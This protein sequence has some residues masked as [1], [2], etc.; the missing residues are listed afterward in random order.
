MAGSNRLSLGSL[1][2]LDA[3]RPL[4]D[5]VYQVLRD[6]IIDGR[7]EAGQWLRQEAL[8]QELGVSQMPIREALKRLV[9]E[10]LAER[11]PYRG[12]QVVEFAPR[13]IADMCTVRL[14]LESLAVRFAATQVTAEQIA[15]LKE[16]LREA[17]TCTR[18]EEMARRRQ[19]N[20]EFHLNICHASEHRY[21]IRQLDA[22]WDWFPSVMLYEG[23]RRQEELS[24]M[25]LERESQEHWAILSAIEEGDP[26]QA[27]ENTRQHI[28][29]LSLELAE[30]LGIREELIEPLMDLSRPPHCRGTGT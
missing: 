12:V 18:H 29:N 10:G 7:F 2:I 11:I 30:V 23:M 27:E 14:I 13:D 16:N 3:Q 28:R 26:I 20:D 6:A 21:L 24:A 1:E 22:L 8:A 4:S 19:L 17:A 25:R 9:A 15:Q 5:R